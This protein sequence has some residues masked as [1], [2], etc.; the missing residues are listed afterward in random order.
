MHVRKLIVCFLV[1]IVFSM[2]VSVAPLWADVEGGGGLDASGLQKQVETAHATA[3]SAALAGNNAWMLTCCALVLFMTAP[4]LAL[5]YGG[6]VRKKNVLGVMMQCF[7]LMGLMTVLWALYGYTLAFGGSFDGLMAEGSVSNPYIGNLDHLFM[8]G[9][10][11]VWDEEAKGPHTPM[12][13]AIPAITFML[14]QG[15]FFIITPALIC[16]AYAERMKFSTMV[17]FTILWGTVVYCPLAHW[18]WGGGILAFGGTDSWAGGA[19]DFAGG[20]V[21]HISSGVSALVCALVLGRRLGWGHEDMRPHNL[22]YTVIGAAM[23]WV[24]WFGF[25][26]GSELASDDLTSSAFATTHFA[27]AAGAIGWAFMEWIARGKPS[28]LGAASGAIAGL[29]CITPGAGFVNLMPALIIG[30]AAGIVCYF[31]CGALKAAFKY[32]DSLDAFGIHGVGG[33]L[34]AI[35]TGVFATRAAW[36]IAEGQPLGLLEGG[37][38]MLGQV[39][40]VV[41]T[42]VYCAVVT[43][44]LL[45]ILDWT[46][47][48]RVSQEGEVRGLD[49][50]EHGEEGYIFV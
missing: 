26:A 18:V 41:V 8:N 36:D 17:V 15:M 2:L 16:G 9:I 32:D 10:E 11:R 23:L 27:A 45:K 12:N 28:V 48:L 34:G 38:V 13:G 1:G 25:N 31:A 40:A 20:T 3:E 24:G 4:G 44:I 35:L 22:T 42:I 6:L 33:T 39:V 29:V 19:L 14:F 50:N 5:F 21:V 47:G 30:A 7:F 49:I 46:M 37:G 43:F